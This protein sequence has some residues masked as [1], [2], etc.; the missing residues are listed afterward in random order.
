M[1]LGLELF[2]VV[3]QYLH[4]GLQSSFVLPQQL[5]LGDELGVTGALRRHREHLWGR[6][7]RGQ[8]LPVVGFFQ[9]V[10]L[11][12]QLPAETEGAGSLASA[13]STDGGEVSESRESGTFV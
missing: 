1:Q 2:V 6:R 4:S 8:A 5:G 13:E 9:P 10:V 7:Q 3:L 12:L 11:R